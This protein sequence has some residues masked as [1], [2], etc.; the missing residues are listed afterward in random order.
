MTT[1]TVPAICEWGE[2]HWCLEDGSPIRL[3]PWQ[4]VVLEA[5]FSA[6][7]QPPKWQTFLISTVKKAGKTELNALATLFSALTFRAP[8]TACRG[9]RR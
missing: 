9:Q 8:E 1:S 5:M 2:R 4:R 6:D 3:R 7:G